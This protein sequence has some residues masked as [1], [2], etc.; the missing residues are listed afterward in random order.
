VDKEILSKSF[1]QNLVVSNLRINY[2]IFDSEI[3]VV[4]IGFA[5]NKFYMGYGPVGCFLSYPSFDRFRNSKVKFQFLYW[6][7]KYPSYLISQCTWR[8]LKDYG[9][10][11]GEINLEPFPDITNILP[12][13]Y[14]NY[15]LAARSMPFP[16]DNLL[17]LSIV[18]KI[19][20]M[21]GGEFVR[22]LYVKNKHKKKEV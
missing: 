17:N 7:I 9:F 11:T 22:G 3:S 16:L 13:S 15:Y 14:K 1:Y 19:K 6:K 8:S 12:S 18:F 10:P 21:K 4:W 20:S 5:K 2:D